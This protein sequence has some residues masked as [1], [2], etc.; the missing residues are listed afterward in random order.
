VLRRPTFLAIKESS[1]PEEE[2]Y[3]HNKTIYFNNTLA[4]EPKY[5]VILN[6]EL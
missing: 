5:E 1:A 6:C 3:I 4:L 2:D